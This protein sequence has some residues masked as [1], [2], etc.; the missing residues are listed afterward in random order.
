MG[1]L[2]LDNLITVPLLH[3]LLQK[4]REV[5]RHTRL[6]LTRHGLGQVNTVQNTLMTG[7]TTRVMMTGIMN[8]AAI[9]SPV[10]GSRSLN[11]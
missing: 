10:N 3:H 2:S 8:I 1:A 11:L 9:L 4:K 6:T 7:H 5:Y